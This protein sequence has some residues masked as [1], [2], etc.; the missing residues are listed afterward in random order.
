MTSELT[1]MIY[2]PQAQR[3]CHS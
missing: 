3:M 2:K 1:D